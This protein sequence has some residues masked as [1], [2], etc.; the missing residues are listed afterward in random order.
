MEDEDKTKVELIKEL[1]ALRK[2]RGG[3]GQ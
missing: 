1:K 2:A 3:G